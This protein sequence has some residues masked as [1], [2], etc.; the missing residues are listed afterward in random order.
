MVAVCAEETV[1]SIDLSTLILE[2]ILST[3][4]TRTFSAFKLRTSFSLIERSPRLNNPPLIEKY[5]I[6]PVTPA[7]PTPEERL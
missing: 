1:L 2:E 3:F 6:M 4:R 7:V 5:V